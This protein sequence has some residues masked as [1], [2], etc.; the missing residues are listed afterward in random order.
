MTMMVLK[1]DGFNS[2][3]TVW[4]CKLFGRSQRKQT[5]RPRKLC[6]SHCKPWAGWRTWLPGTQRSRMVRWMPTSLLLGA[7]YSV[8]ASYT[9]TTVGTKIIADLEKCFQKL[10][11]E[12]LLSL[13]RDG[14][15]PELINFP[16]T[17]RLSSS[18]REIT[19]IG[20]KAINSSKK[21]LKITGPA[22]SRINS[23]IIS[24]RTVYTNYNS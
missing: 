8:L 11:S 16:V 18:W 23:V 10:I 4:P 24:A 21:V 22:L 6:R 1:N 14:P 5:A 9:R 20:L 17:F 3:E 7:S 12:K 15:C 19:G 13:L 2:P